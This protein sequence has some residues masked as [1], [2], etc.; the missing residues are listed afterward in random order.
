MDVSPNVV[1]LQPRRG[2]P[3]HSE[4]GPPPEPKKFAYLKEGL[5][6]HG[7][8]RRISKKHNWGWLSSESC[9]CDILFTLSDVQH[10]PPSHRVPEGCSSLPPDADPA[11]GFLDL[12]SGSKSAG[13]SQQ[14]TGAEQ[15]S[16]T[17]VGT[18]TAGATSVEKPTTETKGATSTTNVGASNDVVDPGAVTNTTTSSTSSEPVPLKRDDVV[19]FHIQLNDRRV[20]Y[21]LEQYN[22]DM[23]STSLATLPSS[24][25]PKHVDGAALVKTAS[26]ASSSA[27]AT[28]GPSTSGVRGS[29]TA[30]TPSTAAYA[31]S[32]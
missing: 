7:R 10:A 31:V 8:I 14:S 28:G 2:A 16:A 19:S 15:G 5:L 18:T 1:G 6:L 24:A 22:A 9:Y 3:R 25:T 29:K 26:T 30:D 21:L 12:T 27:S 23:G 4:S 32:S 11:S 13:T 17:T 20:I